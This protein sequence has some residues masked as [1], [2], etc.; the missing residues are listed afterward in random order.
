MKDRCFI[1]H[2]NPGT[3]ALSDPQIQNFEDAKRRVVS[4]CPYAGDPSRCS[5]PCFGCVRVAGARMA[6]SVIELYPEASEATLALERDFF[7]RRGALPPKALTAYVDPERE[8]QRITDPDQ[9]VQRVWE[10]ARAVLDLRP[11][12]RVPRRVGPTPPPPG[13]VPPVLLRHAEESPRGARP[14]KI[15]RYE[16]SRPRVTAS[17]AAECW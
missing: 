14:G 8:F 3:S 9:V 1:L 6:R 15:S 11:G 2:G 5:P 17:R 7:R 13:D 12:E 4:E 10:H 16:A